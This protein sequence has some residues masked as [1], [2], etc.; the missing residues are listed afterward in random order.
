MKQSQNT[1]AQ[2]Y[3][4][5]AQPKPRI[6]ILTSD[7]PHH[8]FLIR[9]LTAQF[10]VVGIVNEKGA[11][12]H[13]RL[14]ERKKYIDWGYRYY[15]KLRNRWVGYS[16]HRKTFFAV[17]K[18]TQ[19]SPNC[20]VVETRSINSSEVHEAIKRWDAD[21]YICCGTMFIGKTTRTLSQKIINI[22]GGF[23]PDY[24][25]NQC[26]FFAFYERAYDK[27]GATLHFVSNELDGGNM[28]EVVRVPV[29]PHDNDEHLYSRSVYH[30]MLRLI[31]LLKEY[32]QGTPIIGKTQPD[33]GRMFRHRSRGPVHDLRLWLRRKLGQKNVP[34][35]AT[36]NHTKSTQQPTTV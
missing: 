35:M 2:F 28:I 12:Q 7:D 1:I 15:H 3:P 34:H 14:W 10:D 6:G 25:G 29:Y 23:L 33:T 17:D 4:S 18:E 31:E 27:I 36:P 9:Q 24:K 22:H 30:A 11:W 8:H 5:Q 32:E 13:Q 20:E 19:H 21:L 26:I 16:K